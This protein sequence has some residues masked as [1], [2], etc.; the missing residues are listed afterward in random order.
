MEKAIP[1]QSNVHLSTAVTLSRT[2]PKVTPSESACGKL[3][4]YAHNFQELRVK[5]V[6]GC[7]ATLERR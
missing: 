5:V 3:D 1:L 7:C 4:W 2:A 6:L